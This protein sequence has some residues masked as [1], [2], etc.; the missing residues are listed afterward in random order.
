M[1][2]HHLY[3]IFAGTGLRL[4]AFQHRMRQKRIQGVHGFATVSR[5]LVRFEGARCR[6]QFVQVL[7]AGFTLA[8]FFLLEVFAQTGTRDDMVHLLMQW[9]IGGFLRQLVDQLQERSQRLVPLGPKHAGAQ[10]HTAGFPHG[11]AAFA[12]GRAHQIQG[13]RAN[14]ARRQV[15]HTLE[16]GV[17]GAVRQQAQVSKR[18]FHFGALKEAEATVNA[19]RDTRVHEAF[20]QHA[21]LRIGPVQHRC[22]VTTTALID[23]LAHALDYEVRFVAFVERGI[24]TDR[25]ARRTCGTQR[26][27]EA[28]SVVLDDAVGQRQDVAAGAVVFFEAHHERAGKVSAEL[29]DVF[30]LGAAPAVDALVVVTHDE[31]R[32]TR[33]GQQTQPL[34]LQGVGVLKLVHQHVGEA[35]A[36]V[37]QHLHMVAQQF[38]TAQQQFGEVHHARLAAARFIFLVDADELPARRVAVILQVLRALTFI[39]TAIN[40]ISDLTWHPAGVVEAHFFQNFF[41]QPLLVIRIENLEGLRQLGFAPMNA[42]QAMRQA[43]E[44]ADPEILHA[45]LQQRFHAAAHF[46][47]RLVGEGNR[48]DGP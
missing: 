35:L 10:H 31:R 34:V 42:Q 23:P 21:R 27:A 28:A 48:E 13:A 4:A 39:F 38:V 44:G 22:A 47:R 14:A 15:H 7:D 20:F 40:E 6:N 3:G 32:T 16:S 18:I 24:D 25:L 11:V 30:H 26:L 37:V 1:Q 2:R 36:V 8:V 17:F 9:Q 19:V 45:H 33:T 41:H 5:H 43:M 12:R 46:G 29:V